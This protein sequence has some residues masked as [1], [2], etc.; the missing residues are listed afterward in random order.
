MVGESHLPPERYSGDIFRRQQCSCRSPRLRGKWPPPSP[1]CLHSGVQRE[2]R[3]GKEWSDVSTALERGTCLLP[4]KVKSLDCTFLLT[5]RAGPSP[6]SVL[7]R[8]CVPFLSSCM[9][10]WS[11]FLGST[12]SLCSLLFSSGGQWAPRGPGLPAQ[13][14]SLGLSHGQLASLKEAMEKPPV[15]IARVCMCV[16]KYVLA[17]RVGGGSWRMCKW[18]V[19]VNLHVSAPLW[20]LKAHQ[21]TFPPRP[22]QFVKASYKGPLTFLANA[23]HTVLSAWG[24]P[25][26]LLSVVYVMKTIDFKNHFL[27]EIYRV[28]WNVHFKSNTA[29]RLLTA[30]LET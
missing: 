25:Q 29:T 12:A 24:T 21:Q 4:K 27:V 15:Q 28:I 9:S 1:C 7:S 14:F 6:R 22:C 5:P 2:I 26:A 10:V 11:V 30:S 20:S 13:H 23:S 8:P 16:Q 18:C 19:P 17:H 3:E